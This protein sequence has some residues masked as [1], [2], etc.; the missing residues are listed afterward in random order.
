M[1]SAE[2]LEDLQNL[3]EEIRNEYG[4]DHI[5]YHWVNSAGEQYGCGTY[6][7]EW[8]NRYVEKNYLRIDP[9]VQGCYQHFHPVNWKRLDWSSKAARALRP[10]RRS[11]R[12]RPRPRRARAA[13]P[14]P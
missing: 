14:A 6:D 4:V 13:P 8:V 3:I 9:V 10:A 2:G 11:R 7:L 12:R 5:V 1:E